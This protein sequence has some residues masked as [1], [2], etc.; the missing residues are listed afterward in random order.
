MTIKVAVPNLQPGW[1]GGRRYLDTIR[2]GLSDLEKE[3]IVEV[4]KYPRIIVNENHSRRKYGLLNAITYSFDAIRGINALNVPRPMSGFSKKSL[5]WIPDLQDIERPDFFNSEELSRREN[6][7]KNHL[8]NKRAFFF[9]SGHALEVFNSIGYDEP[10]IA[11]ILRFATIFES[12]IEDELSESFCLGCKENGFFYLPNQWWVHKNHKWALEAFSEYQLQGGTAHLVL[13]GIEEDSR[14]PDYSADEVFS[15]L[16]VNNVHRFGM[17][18]RSIQRKFYST[19]IAVIQPSSYEGWSTTIEEALS[20]GA[21][22]IAS[23][24]PTNIEQLFDCPDTTV[25]RSES[26]SAL[27]QA[28]ISPPKKLEE[29]QIDAR[30]TYRWKRFLNDLESTITLGDKLIRES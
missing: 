24:I 3:G 28:L 16:K 5:A 12:Q 17:V 10:L 6:M 25:V 19:A 13:T 14:W 7:R 21:P 20:L 30:L 15:I 26:L 9:S 4:Y 1:A 8:Q 2:A 27:V 23:N 29:A 18:K 22:I 11:G